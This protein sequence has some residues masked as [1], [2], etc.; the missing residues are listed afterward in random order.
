VRQIPRALALLLGAL[1]VAAPANAAVPAKKSPSTAPAR[2]SPQRRP[3]APAPA[4]ED[5]PPKKEGPRAFLDVKTWYLD[6]EVTVVSQGPGMEMHSSTTVKVA[7]DFSDLGPSITINPEAASKIDPYDFA[8]HLGD[9]RYWIIHPPVRDDPGMTQRW[10]DSL[11]APQQLTYRLD[12]GDLQ[13]HAQGIGKLMPGGGALPYQFEVDVHRKIYAFKCS[14]KFL[15]VPSTG[16]SVRGET[17]RKLFEGWVTEPLDRPFDSFFPA[18]KSITPH[19][20]PHEVILRGTLPQEVGTIAATDSFRFEGYG[21]NG[22]IVIHYSLSPTPPEAIELVIQG[23]QPYK[24]W[25]PDGADDEL[26]PGP[27]PWLVVAKLQKRGG[28]PPAYK[29]TRF[30]Y[31]LLNT[32]KE[33]GVCM[34]WPPSPLAE[35][36]F[37]L[38]L[39]GDYA[40]NGPSSID[41]D[42]DGQKG[43]ETRDGM[44]EAKIR[45][46]SYDWGAHAALQIVADLENGNQVVGTVEGTGERSLK[47]PYRKTGSNVGYLWAAFRS[48]L[49]VPDDADRED[50]PKGDG[51]QGDGFTQ[52]EEYRGFME[53]GKWTDADPRKKDVFVLNTLRT[54][55]SVVLGIGLYQ[56]ITDLAVHAKLVETEV[57]LDKVVNFNHSAGPHLVDQH[58][59]Y[60][61][62]GGYKDEETGLKVSHVNEVGTPGT[63]GAVNLCVERDADDP[64]DEHSYISGATVAHEMLH[65]SN[66]FHHGD[67]DTR[68]AW[69]VSEDPSGRTHVTESSGG[70]IFGASGAIATVA[71]WVGVGEVD[72]RYEDNVRV[73][74]I[75]AGDVLWMG[76]QFGQHS[77][78]CECVMRYD[79]SVVYRSLTDPAVRYLA[80]PKERGGRSLCASGDGTK[81]N[82][83]ARRTP[84][85]RYGPAATGAGSGVALPRGD[86]KHQIRVNDMGEEPHR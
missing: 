81:V 58:V 16:T 74:G 63:A 25:R 70:S 35:Q 22:T 1:I 28:G 32:S 54:V 9:A 5:E 23:G 85:P 29:A 46:E 72:V 51:F 30:T 79:V 61:R 65:S 67:R 45:V 47:L 68:V 4:D 53:G 19:V 76:E 82:D 71:S 39:H 37:D 80:I 20:E 66:V 59:I 75:P 83:A 69:H 17:R 31:R 27:N 26:T 44:T 10:L 21:E 62:E 13:V 14:Y 24:T 86:C 2:R 49:N 78:D 33:Q 3:A 15:D 6:Y 41:I 7:L 60:I 56:T 11:L 48:V 40:G 64:A 18:M 52:Y 50:L 84:Q 42:P 55:P 36:P 34:N 38:K 12:T 8:K 77:G 43:V 73:A 57:Q